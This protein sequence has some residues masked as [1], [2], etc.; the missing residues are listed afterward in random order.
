MP[1]PFQHLEHCDHDFCSLMWAN[2]T[3]AD[4]FFLLPSSTDRRFILTVALS[5]LSIGFSCSP[6]VLSWIPGTFIVKK[7][8]TTWL[9]LGSPKLSAWY[10]C[11]FGSYGDLGIK[12]K[13]QRG[14]KQNGYQMTD[15]RVACTMDTRTRPSRPGMSG[16]QS[17]VQDI[18]QDC[19]PAK[20]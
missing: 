18:V 5:N 17:P 7:K 20:A 8:N 6:S 14:M 12:N 9:L 19:I 3:N 2:T 10:S 4:S 1:F 16:R 13:M 11:T 15:R